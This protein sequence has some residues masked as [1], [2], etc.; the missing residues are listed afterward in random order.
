MLYETIQNSCSYNPLVL[1]RHLTIGEIANGLAHTY[2]LEQIKDTCLVFEDDTIF[3]E[4]FIHHLYH[5]FKVLPE[6]WEIVCLG[7]PTEIQKFPFKTLDSSK[8]KI[9]FRRDNII[10]STSNSVRIS[11]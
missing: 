2:V 10:F 8:K 4:N 9:L 11:L 3:K 6:N 1:K 5:I 7:G